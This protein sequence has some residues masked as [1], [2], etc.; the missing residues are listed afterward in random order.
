MREKLILPQMGSAK[1]QKNGFLINL[2]GQRYFAK[3][4]NIRQ[5]P[6]DPP[7]SAKIRQNPPDSAKI[8]KISQPEILFWPWSRHHLRDQAL[9][10]A[11][12]TPSIRCWGKS[13]VSAFFAFFAFFEKFCEN[14]YKILREILRKILR[15][16]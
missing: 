5:N 8:C 3:F 9:G 10:K 16:I 11:I 15:K 14:Q 1:N 6:Q 12:E 4:C 2:K 7:K 13:I